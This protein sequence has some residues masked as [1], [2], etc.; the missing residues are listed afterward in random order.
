MPSAVATA[1]GSPGRAAGPLLSAS[2]ALVTLAGLY[3]VV[4]AALPYYGM[5]ADQFTTT[6]PRRSW[7][8]LHITTGIVALFSGPVQLWLGFADRRPRLHRRLGLIYL[9]SVAT[10]SLAAYYLALRTDAGFGFGAGLAGLA[11]AWVVTT[12]LAYLAIRRQLF[13]LHQEW[14]VRSYVV[15]TG[16]ITFRLLVEILAAGGVGSPLERLTVAAWFCW[17]VPLLLT[18]AIL[19]GRKILR[20]RPS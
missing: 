19:Q 20:V 13:E 16:F 2:L 1:S 4:V 3:F 9:V 14:M 17:S 15:T 11:T 10:S 18:E 12:G 6:W 7:L 5:R 8:L